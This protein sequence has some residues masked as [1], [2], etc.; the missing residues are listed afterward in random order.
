MKINISQSL[1]RKVL[2]AVAGATSYSVTKSVVDNNIEEAENRR[3][4]AT[5]AIGTAIIAWAVSDVVA[6]HVDEKISEFL[7]AL[8]HEEETDE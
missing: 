4:K 6:E 8:N 3:Q 2:V 7:S 5:F 1:I